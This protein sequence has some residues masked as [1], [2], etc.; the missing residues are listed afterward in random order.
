VWGR[1]KRSGGK[2][3]GGRG[4]GHR[5]GGGGSARGATVAWGGRGRDEGTDDSRR[6]RGGSQ[7][8]VT[9][10]SNIPLNQTFERSGAVRSRWEPVAGLGRPADP[11]GAL[12][13]THT[14]SLKTTRRFRHARLPAAVVAAEAPTGGA[15]APRR[16]ATVCV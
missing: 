5:L 11:R 13:G 2:E 12:V 1:A 10:G 15:G 14:R 3:G 7:S 9:S 8:A 4:G 16:G 6:C